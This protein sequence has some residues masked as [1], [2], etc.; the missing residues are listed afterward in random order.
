MFLLSIYTCKFHAKTITAS[1]LRVKDRQ[2][3]GPSQN[4]WICLDIIIVAKSA[5]WKKTF[6]ID[7]LIE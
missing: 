5:R 1:Q 6:G 4:D 2:V 7:Q 3:M